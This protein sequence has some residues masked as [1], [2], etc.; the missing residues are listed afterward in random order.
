MG[1]SR[2]RSRDKSRRRKHSGDRK[3]GRSEDLERDERHRPQTRREGPAVAVGP[4][5]DVPATLDEKCCLR[6][7]IVGPRGSVSKEQVMNELHSI[8]LDGKVVHVGFE[9]GEAA[10]PQFV[11][12]KVYFGT[13]DEAD[14][15]IT[16][17]N[18]P[19]RTCRWRVFVSQRLPL[20]GPFS[21]DIGSDPT[22]QPYVEDP[23]DCIVVDATEGFVY[24]ST[25][26][27]YRTK[28][29][30]D[31][32]QAKRQGKMIRRLVCK[33]FDPQRKL[34]CRYGPQCTFLH[35]KPHCMNRLLRTVSHRQALRIPRNDDVIQMSSWEGDRREDTLLVR[36]LD[37]SLDQAGLTY[38]FE[39]CAGFQECFLHTLKDG[40]AYG[41]IRFDSQS[42]A[43]AALVQTIGSGLN[44]S[45]CGALEDI[46][47]LLVREVKQNPD[48]ERLYRQH[49]LEQQKM[50]AN[51]DGG[52]RAGGPVGGSTEGA[53]SA[54][55]GAAAH[56]AGLPFPPLPEGWVY[57][58]SRRNNQYYFYRLNSKD[59]TSWKHPVTK[60]SYTAPI[61]SR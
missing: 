25:D 1:R 19:G 33:H 49:L 43:F 35:V 6:L 58:M 8:K 39:G 29:L 24:F 55:G 31:C 36:D 30:E 50:Y 18:A 9:G 22:F 54:A 3:R 10:H 20:A 47:G 7:G 11:W 52:E 21:G 34:P 61:G 13:P 56:D 5:A 48:G 12:V 53:V 57:G 32:F 17:L 37:S 4:A 41:I 46:R 14:E 2:S 44:I 15:A 45:F 23:A 27:M 38:M 26:E 42:N 16:E 40:R 28:G 59:D 60:E 51:A